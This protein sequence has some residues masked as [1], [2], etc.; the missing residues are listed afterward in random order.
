MAMVVRL[1][2]AWDGWIWK[3][4]R[5]ADGVDPPEGTTGLVNSTKREDANNWHL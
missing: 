1:F 2:E 4:I 5:G 3:Q